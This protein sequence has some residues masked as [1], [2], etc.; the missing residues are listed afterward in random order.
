[1]STSMPAVL[2]R[3]LGGEEVNAGWWTM[4][5]SANR[6]FAWPYGTA[7]RRVGP[8]TPSGMPEKRALRSPTR[9]LAGNRDSPGLDFR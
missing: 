6:L 9:G 2:R 8:G 7:K 5:R 3:D 1:M 4:R